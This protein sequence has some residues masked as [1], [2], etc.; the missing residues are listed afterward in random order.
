MWISTLGAF[1]RRSA[2]PPICL[3]SSSPFLEWLVGLPTGIFFW[4][5]GRTEFLKDKENNI[6][7]PFQNYQGHRQRNFVKM[8]DRKMH[9]F[10]YESFES[11]KMAF[12]K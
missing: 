9:D 3:S 2:F 10:D 1:T 11:K 5:N 6:A 7:R 4:F 8:E 12:N